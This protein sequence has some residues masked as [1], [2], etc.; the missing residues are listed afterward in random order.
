MANLKASDIS[1][2][3]P[4]SLLGSPLLLPF[5]QLPPNSASASAIDS[6]CDSR[7]SRLRPTLQTISHSSHI[8][9]VSLLPSGVE[10]QSSSLQLLLQHRQPPEQ[11]Q[12]QHLHL[13]AYIS[14][15]SDIANVW[16]SGSRRVRR[17]KT[18]VMDVTTLVAVALVC[19]V[20]YYC[21]RKPD[22]FPPGEAI[23]RRRDSCRRKRGLES[24]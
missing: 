16:R 4:P 21:S 1:R 24:Q 22:R 5:L 23:G 12:G 11:H 20:F 3:T 2:W 17:R 15:F 13:C 14:V 9:S 6:T 8:S 18:V 7:H 10:R 19:L